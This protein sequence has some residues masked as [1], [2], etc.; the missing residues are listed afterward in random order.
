ML[1][2]SSS[3]TDPHDLIALLLADKRSECTR[4]A[5]DADLRDFFAYLGAYDTK[6]PKYE[7]SAAIVPSSDTP[8]T[9]SMTQGRAENTREFAA[10]PVPMIALQMGQ[11]KSAMLGR[12]LSE[13][14][15]NRRLAAIKSLLK[16]AH[17]L[18]ISRTDGRGLCDGERVKSY[19]DTRGVDMKTLRKLMKSPVLRWETFCKRHD[20]PLHI[21]TYIDKDS[22]RECTEQNAA[23][24]K[25]IAI[26]REIYLRDVAILTLLIEN[27][28]RRAEVC[29]LNRSDLDAST[30]SLWI[31]GKARGQQKERIT[32][33]RDALQSIA[34]YLQVRGEDG[35]PQGGNAALFLNCDRRGR[36]RLTADGLYQ[37]VGG[38]G[39]AIGVANLTPHKLR[40]SA[41]TALLDATK[42][43]VRR[44]Q[45]LSRHAKIETLMIYDDARRD[46]QGEMSN[47]LSGMLK[48]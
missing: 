28:L 16:F 47:L 26:E 11:Y 33:S 3:Q 17:R 7:I 32:V 24:Q 43:D 35:N 41:I 5:Y 34:A 25:N 20:L 42:G 8:V 45:R 27:A 46:E 22:V 18:G 10:Q 40:H 1:A 38:H 48:K 23:S 2:F 37:I 6:A 21:H 19:R 29:K 4:R 30:C 39:R 14:T 15:V 13:A 36:S 44:V 9:Q 31:L 12:G